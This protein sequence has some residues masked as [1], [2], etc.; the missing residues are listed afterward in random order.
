M[1]NTDQE[2]LE[3][4]ALKFKESKLFDGKCAACGLKKKDVF[5]QPVNRHARRHF[6]EMGNTAFVSLCGYCALGFED[7]PGRGARSCIINDP[8]EREKIERLLI[9]GWPFNKVAE[10]T[11]HSRK[12]VRLIYNALGFTLKCPCGRDSKHLG[13]CMVRVKRS[14]ARLLFLSKWLGLNSSD[15][16]Y[17]AKEKTKPIP[18]YERPH[19]SYERETELPL[20]VGGKMISL[21]AEKDG[22]DDRTMHASVGASCPTEKFGRQKIRYD[23]G[24]E[25]RMDQFAE[26]LSEHMQTVLWDIDSASDEDRERLLS[27]A[28]MFKLRDYITT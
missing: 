13:L 5:P 18:E 24:M 7:Q 25:Y 21:D 10:M 15:D 16:L 6:I 9:L 12:T 28:D 2:A 27:D 1:K 14:P 26:T 17:Q 20:L 11:S 3:S 19:I 22:D 8:V 4:A 23:Y